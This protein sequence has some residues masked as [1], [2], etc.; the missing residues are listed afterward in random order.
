MYDCKVYVG[1]QSVNF[2]I[3]DG[4]KVPRALEAFEPVPVASPVGGVCFEYTQTR[5]LGLFLSKIL[6]KSTVTGEELAGEYCDSVKQ[7]DG[8]SPPMKERIK[9]LL[10]RRRVQ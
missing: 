8:Y 5:T 10:K 1:N 9:R 2:A 6:D 7:Q 3:A 4:L